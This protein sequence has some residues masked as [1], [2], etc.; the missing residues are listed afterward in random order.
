MEFKTVGVANYEILQ[1]YQYA[2]STGTVM[3]RSRGSLI[4]PVGTSAFLSKAD[5]LVGETAPPFFTCFFIP[6]FPCKICEDQLRMNRNI[7]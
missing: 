2:G 3:V 1:L 5:S 7:I 6:S 4:H